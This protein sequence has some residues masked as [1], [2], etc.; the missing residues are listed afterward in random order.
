MLWST[1]TDYFVAGV[2]QFVD[3]VFYFTLFRPAGK[4]EM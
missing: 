3:N 1:E 4:F 2:H